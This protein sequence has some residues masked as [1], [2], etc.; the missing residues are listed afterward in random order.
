MRTKRV[1]NKL[2]PTIKEGYKGNKVLNGRFLNEYKGPENLTFYEFAKWLLFD[3][4]HKKAKRKYKKEFRVKSRI[5]K[6]LPTKTKDNI[7]WLGH[8]SF[9]ITMG[10]KRVLM[11]P[12]LRKIFP[13]PRYAKIPI[14]P[15]QLGPID[16][17]C[18][19][20]GHRD[21]LDGPTLRRLQTKKIF[22]PLGAK[23]IAEKYN[24]T[25]EIEA[26]G[27]WQQHTTDNDIK[28]YFLPAYHWHARWITDKDKVLWGSYVIKTKEKTV[29]FCG[30]T[31]YTEHFKDIHKIFPKIDACIMPTTFYK[32]D[33]IMAAEHMSIKES[34]KAFDILKGKLFIPM[35]YGTIGL[36]NIGVKP[37]LEETK[38]LFKKRKRKQGTL[39]F[40]DVGETTTF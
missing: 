9:L 7:T 5:I 15:E 22:L 39:K 12:L 23:R 32:P 16:Y 21:H 2:L 26:A 19:S 6:K 3:N 25:T 13:I 31:A 8:A 20:H 24:K 18:I 29:F 27:W 30:D 17:T 33:N 1:K 11:D 4:E 36:G 35:H 40:L 38:S 14:S 28:I 34:I 10:G 37:T